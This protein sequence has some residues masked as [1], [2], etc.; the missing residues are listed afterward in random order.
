M[1]KRFVVRGAWFVVLGSW[2]LVLGSWLL[3]GER[4]DLRNPGWLGG[5]RPVVVSGGTLN[6]LTN[7]LVAYLKMDSTNMTDSWGTNVFVG[8]AP[9]VT[10][11]SKI[12]SAI[13]LPGSAVWGY[14]SSNAVF[15][16]SNF[17]VSVWLK[18]YG[19]DYSVRVIAQY[20]DGAS[21]YAWKM[22]NYGVPSPYRLWTY[23][24][25][26]TSYQESLVSIKTNTWYHFAVSCTPTNDVIYTN[27]VAVLTNI[28]PAKNTNLNFQLYVGKQVFASTVFNGIMDEMKYWRTNKTGLE[29][30]KD[31]TNGLNGTA[32]IP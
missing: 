10:N 12:G 20:Y 27:G 4:F 19:E 28:H 23:T 18:N 2:C 14:I 1:M 32:L 17:T 6:I 21:A 11:D 30:G 25:N 16:S 31:Y 3:A 29:I 7:D 22:N 5:V 26:S 13:S 8:N 9:N 24:N 15:N